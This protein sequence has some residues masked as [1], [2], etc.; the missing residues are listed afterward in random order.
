MIESRSAGRPVSVASP[1]SNDRACAGIELVV[2]LQSAIRGSR[3]RCEELPNDYAF[4]LQLREF[5][6]KNINS[7][8]VLSASSSGDL[9]TSLTDLL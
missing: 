7:L 6:R 4:R 3:Q 2:W 5:N 9:F 8:S 1:R